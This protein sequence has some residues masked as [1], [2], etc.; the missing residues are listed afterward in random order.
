MADPNQIFSTRVV[1]ESPAGIALLRRAPTGEFQRA[2]ELPGGK[3]EIGEDP[4]AAAV[5][6]PWEELGLDVEIINYHP[7]LIDSRVISDGKHKGKLYESVGF[8][9]FSDSDDARLS[10]EHTDLRWLRPG[11]LLDVDTLTPTSFRTLFKMSSLC[12]GK[13]SF[14]RS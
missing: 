2:W 10:A 12:L 8:V 13:Y 1:V 7:L 3:I 6:E 9:A 11:K 4:L 14:T 5:R